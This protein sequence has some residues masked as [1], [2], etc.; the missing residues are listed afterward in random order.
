M[1]FLEDALARFAAHG[2]VVERVMTDNGPPS[3][4]GCSYEPLQ[5]RG[6]QHTRTRPST[7]RISGKAARFIPARRRF[8]LRRAGT[9]SCSRAAAP[10]APRAIPSAQ[11]SS[12]CAEG[13]IQT[14]WREWA[15]ASP[16]HASAEPAAPCSHGSATTAPGPAPPSAERPPP[17]ASTGTTSSATTAG[18]YSSRDCGTTA[19]RDGDPGVIRTR[20]LLIRNQLLYPAELRGPGKPS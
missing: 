10:P 17:A 7:L 19:E 4:A 13:I 18:A 2:G 1:R 5:A 9:G 20:D 16:F 11:R 6:L 12:R 8:D 3:E 15:Q 14:S